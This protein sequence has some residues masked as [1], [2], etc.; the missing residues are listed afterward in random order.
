LKGDKLEGRLK[1]LGTLIKVGF[2]KSKPTVEFLDHSA[3][4]GTMMSRGIESRFGPP[5]CEGQDFSVAQFG[6]P[7][8]HTTRDISHFSSR[9]I[10]RRD[11]LQQEHKQRRPP[12]IKNVSWSG[13]GPEQT[14]GAN[15]TASPTTPRGN[16]TP[17]CSNTPGSEMRR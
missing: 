7:I 2:E 14:L 4:R 13:P 5:G 8:P 9:P 17:R 16:S 11:F 6:P 10:G 15:S 12:S 1:Y 3:G